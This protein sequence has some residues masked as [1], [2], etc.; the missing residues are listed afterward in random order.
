[1]FETL[2]RTTFLLFLAWRTAAIPGI[3]NYL[4]LCI[5]LSLIFLVGCESRHPANVRHVSL[6][7]FVVTDCKANGSKPVSVKGSAERYCLSAKPVV[8]ETDVRLA[9]AR[10]DD[11]SGRPVLDLYF[12]DKTGQR[13]KDV[14]ECLYAE[15]LR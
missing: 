12:T 11:E 4:K 15:H 9:E 7:I 8:D 14:T 1:M 2:H 6:G 3:R 5:L 13:M 10:R